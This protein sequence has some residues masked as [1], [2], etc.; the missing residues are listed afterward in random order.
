M[1]EASVKSFIQKVKT[2]GE[3][4]KKLKGFKD[5]K[6]RLAFVKEAGFEFTD[7]EIKAIQGELSDEDLDAVAG[8]GCGV[9][10]G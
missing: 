4:T 3:F 8:A 2:D 10:K 5:A 6:A 9:K 1:S 7:A